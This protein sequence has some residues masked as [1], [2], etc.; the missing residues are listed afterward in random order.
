MTWPYKTYIWPAETAVLLA[1]LL[2]KPA[3]ALANRRNDP[4]GYHVFSDMLLLPE[5]TARVVD[6]SGIRASLGMVV[7]E[8]PTQ[9]GKR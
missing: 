6:S 5:A 7:I 2:W 9:L 3:L 1:M 4:C 8:F